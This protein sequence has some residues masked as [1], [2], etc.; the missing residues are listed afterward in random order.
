MGSSFGHGS[1]NNVPFSSRVNP[2]LNKSNI[3]PLIT[4]SY[5]V[6][7]E[8]VRHRALEKL[9]VQFVSDVVYHQHGGFSDQRL[10]LGVEAK[11]CP[12]QQAV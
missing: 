8:E 5:S 4:V 2:D 10:F 9:D 1:G 6:D 3:G 7:G 12:G 11:Y